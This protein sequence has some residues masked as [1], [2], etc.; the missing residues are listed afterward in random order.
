MTVLLLCGLFSGLLLAETPR[1]FQVEVN[2]DL[3][4]FPIQMT[5]DWTISDLTENTAVFDFQPGICSINAVHVN[6]LPASW[7]Q[8]GNQ[9]A[10]EVDSPTPPTVISFEWHVTPDSQSDSI[11]KRDTE[12]THSITAIGTPFGPSRWIPVPSG[13]ETC[14]TGEFSFIM[15]VDMDGI[16]TG[17]RISDTATTEGHCVRFEI[18]SPVFPRQLFFSMASGREIEIATLSTLSGDRPLAIYPYPGLKQECETDLAP[19]ST[20]VPILEQWF[21]TFPDTAAHVFSACVMD[22]DQV[23]AVP[24]ILAL[25]QG[26][27]T[28]EGDINNR[29]ANGLAGQWWGYWF[30]VYNPAHSWVTE[31]LRTYSE[32]LIKAVETTDSEESQVDL[33]AG[34]LQNYDLGGTTLE[35]PLVVTEG[36]PYDHPYVMT[37]KGAYT[38]H[39]LRTISGDDLF[40]NGLKRLATLDSPATATNRLQFALE[41]ETRFPIGQ[42]LR[43]WTLR[44]PR[45]VLSYRFDQTGDRLVLDVS[46]PDPEDNGGSFQIPLQVVQ[47]EDTTTVWLTEKNQRFFLPQSIGTPELDPYSHILKLAVSG[48]PPLDAPGLDFS[49]STDITTYPFQ[50]V[51]N[52]SQLPEGT[53]SWRIDGIP[54][55]LTADGHLPVRESG[56]HAVQLTVS[57]PEQITVS[58]IL[59]VQIPHPDGDVNGDEIVNTAD[60]AMV[61]GTDTADPIPNGIRDEEDISYLAH[62]LLKKIRDR[63]T[64]TP[65]VAETTNQWQVAL[66]TESISVAAGHT[67]SLSLNIHGS[68]ALQ[69]AVI[70]LVFDPGKLEPI[71]TIAA[72][73]VRL[74][75]SSVTGST[76]TLVLGCA[77]I[78]LDCTAD[79]GKVV[80]TL[81]FRALKDSCV[82]TILIDEETCIF[83]HEDNIALL[84]SAASTELSFSEGTIQVPLVLNTDKWETSLGLIETGNNSDN[85]V[86]TALD[87]DGNTIATHS[88][89]LEPGQR[90]LR[91]MADF[92]GEVSTIA[93]IRITGHSA[94]RAWAQYRDLENTAT[95][96]CPASA[97]IETQLLVPHLAENNYWNTLTGIVNCG[98]DSFPLIFSASGNEITVNDNTPAGGGYHGRFINLLDETLLQ[99]GWGIFD[100]NNMPL[101]G[102][103]LFYRVDSLHQAA[104]LRLSDQTACTFYFPH[105]AVNGFW[106]TGISLINPGNEAATITMEAFDTD[107]HAIPDN[108]STTGIATFSL[109]GQTRRVDLVE[110]FFDKQLDPKAAWIKVTSDKPLTGLEIFGS[111]GGFQEDLSA[112]LEAVSEPSVSMTFPW[113]TDGENGQW[114]GLAL[115]NPDETNPAEDITITLLTEDGTTVGLAALYLEPLQKHVVLIRDLFGG[116]VPPGGA[117]LKVQSDL[118]LVGFELTGDDDHQWLMGLNGI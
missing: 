88:L 26:F 76:W 82:S 61:L 112:G 87:N 63:E 33:A 109:P 37:A 89:V 91:K 31:G 67:A 81:R 92:F 7:N 75:F 62:L 9:L 64:I 55:T 102:A 35:G 51:S 40:F 80:S 69:L 19:I 114:C 6:G 42:F 113:A 77:D 23:V 110:N 90:L 38:L 39:M 57:S 29:L 86:L 116:T 30:P 104:A 71:S 93:S 83:S 25:G 84:P 36:N 16:A 11:R 117:Y 85:I 47:N 59:T 96:A 56:T 106:W 94:V 34:I 99:G 4:H 100:G 22:F 20:L 28:G 101:A 43:Q 3:C 78:G 45:P 12:N 14:L 1:Q 54:V 49:I 8:S 46:Q 15:P 74:L 53:C 73:G 68:S 41:K 108:D 97:E 13:F 66:Q 70:K 103:E 72:S 111:R 21:G 18:I 95:A 27:I 118:P 105:I 79:G 48:C 17:S 32:I 65:A 52:Y 5:A 98:P 2:V 107:G 115:L 10:V 58:Q 60:L 50:L 44:S 24:G